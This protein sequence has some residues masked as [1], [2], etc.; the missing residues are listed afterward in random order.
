MAE[1]IDKNALVESFTE[2]IKSAEI[3]RDDCQDLGT[4]TEY[5]D[6]AIIDFNESRMRVQNFPTV[7]AVKVVRCKDCRFNDPNERDK[8]L[9]W[10]PCMSV[11][12]PSSWFCGSAERKTN[13]CR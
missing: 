1:Y 3:W 13:G 9:E 12:K 6:R 2:T 4:T 8:S 7:D 5:A 10:L 11:D